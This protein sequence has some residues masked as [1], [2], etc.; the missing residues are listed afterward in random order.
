M[1]I[2]EVRNKYGGAFNENNDGDGVVLSAEDSGYFSLSSSSCNL[3]FGS[4]LQRIV[5]MKAER[6]K[7]KGE[8]K[9]GLEKEVRGNALRKEK[10]IDGDI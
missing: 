5:E 9:E 6:E 2:Y 1:E 4:R 8:K 3:F 10:K 7:K